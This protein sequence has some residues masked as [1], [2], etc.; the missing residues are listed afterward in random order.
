MFGL[1]AFEGGIIWTGKEAS[2]ALCSHDHKQRNLPLS[3]ILARPPMIDLESN[4]NGRAMA[5]PAFD[6][7]GEYGRPRNHR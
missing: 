7:S 2:M 4:K 1:N 5:D 6:I 3:V